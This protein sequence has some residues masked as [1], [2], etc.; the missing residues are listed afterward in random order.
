MGLTFFVMASHIRK[1]LSSLLDKVVC[2]NKLMI[3][4]NMWNGW[5][6]TSFMSETAGS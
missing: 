1:G 6:S 3:S 2:A 4:A 5:F